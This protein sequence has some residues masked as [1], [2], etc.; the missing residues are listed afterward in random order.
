MSYTKSHTLIPYCL[1]DHNQGCLDARPP[2]PPARPLR[3]I[4]LHV[5]LIRKYSSI[6]EHI[7][8]YSRYFKRIFREYNLYLT[9][10]G[11]NVQFWTF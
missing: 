6:F 8:V 1:R 5:H 3:L 2:G 7:Q 9:S 11:Q 10:Y 4:D